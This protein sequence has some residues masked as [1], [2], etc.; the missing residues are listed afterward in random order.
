MQ[1][2]YRTLNQRDCL[3][4]IQFV[5]ERCKSAELDGYLYDCMQHPTLRKRK[6]GCLS[7][8]SKAGNSW[9]TL[10]QACKLECLSLKHT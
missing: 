2:D 5:L 10:Q 4:V 8:I 6:H 3:E 1:C 9:F 7:G